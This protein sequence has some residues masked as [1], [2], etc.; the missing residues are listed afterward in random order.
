[1]EFGNDT[2]LIAKYMFSADHLTQ[3]SV[4]AFQEIDVSVNLV[5]FSIINIKKGKLNHD[6]FLIKG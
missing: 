3:M 6:I 2:V 4:Q 5:K 1:M